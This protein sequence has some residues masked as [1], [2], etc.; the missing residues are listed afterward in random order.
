MHNWRTK[1]QP[2]AP[3]G[4]L[5]TN[6]QVNLPV[7]AQPGTVVLP[8]IRDEGPPPTPAPTPPP[9]PAPTPPPEPIACPVPPRE[10]PS[11]EA[12][13]KWVEA[14]PRCPEP[15]PWVPAVPGPVPSN[16]TNNNALMQY[17][18]SLPT[19]P[20]AVTNDVTRAP[21][22]VSVA[23]VQPTTEPSLAQRVLAS[24]VTHVLGGAVLGS[25]ATVLV[26]RW[27]GKRR[28]P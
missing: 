8:L 2:T 20:P 28:R 19:P 27:T 14:N 21:Q 11:R 22:E 26:M 25:V 16:G 12:R 13:E 10:F 7:R 9:T 18:N 5:R 24:H 6:T 4:A 17:E 1:K 3:T 15:P 23:P